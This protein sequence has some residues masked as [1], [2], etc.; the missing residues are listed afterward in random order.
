MG[1]ET[2]NT[3]RAAQ[4]GTGGS[5]VAAQRGNDEYRALEHSIGGADIENIVDKTVP[6]SPLHFNQP[7][8]SLFCQNL[9]IICL[10]L[11]PQKKLCK[12]LTLLCPCVQ[13]ELNSSEYLP[14]S[15]MLDLFIVTTP[16]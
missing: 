7:E 10:Q 8:F 6:P 12:A 16:G 5:V 15:N 11:P 3:G 2:L 1:L 9:Y 4:S 13:P 14:A